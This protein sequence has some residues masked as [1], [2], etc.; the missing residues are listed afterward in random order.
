MKPRVTA[1]EL[2][3]ITGIEVSTLF[4]NARILREVL[5]QETLDDKEKDAEVVSA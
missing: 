3:E 4:T 1:V 2:A 5:N